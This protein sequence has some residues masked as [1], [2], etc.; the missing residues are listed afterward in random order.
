MEVLLVL[1]LY[2]AVVVGSD[3]WITPT[4]KKTPRKG[5]KSEEELIFPS[6]NGQWKISNKGKAFSGVEEPPPSDFRMRS[7]DEE[8]SKKRRVG[9]GRQHPMQ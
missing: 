9:H 1:D 6:M 8:S 2:S 4:R 5:R 7:V 3:S